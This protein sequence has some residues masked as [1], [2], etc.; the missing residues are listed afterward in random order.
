MGLSF[1]E[2]YN[3]TDNDEIHCQYFPQFPRFLE[4]PHDVIRIILSYTTNRL[5]D[6]CLVSKFIELTC[7]QL[8]IDMKYKDHIY[9]ELTKDDINIMMCLYDAERIFN[10]NKNNIY[11]RVTHILKPIDLE[12]H[13]MKYIKHTIFYLQSNGYICKLIRYP[14]DSGVNYT[15]ET[16]E[17]MN[18]FVRK[19][20]LIFPYFNSNHI[21][22]L[23]LNYEI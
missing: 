18:M 9:H 1:S 10:V 8:R 14:R 16:K 22:T 5:T 15:N 6:L 23:K 20:K 3:E 2:C 7:K 12:I 4:L 13:Q 21:K 17:E 19:V 11:P